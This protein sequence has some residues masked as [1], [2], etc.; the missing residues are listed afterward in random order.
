LAKIRS[1]TNLIFACLSPHPSFPPR[2][3]SLLWYPSRACRSC[4][5]RRLVRLFTHGTFLMAAPFLAPERATPWVAAA[6]SNYMVHKA[7][8]SG[9]FEV[10]YPASETVS[11]GDIKRGALV[12]LIPRSPTQ[13]ARPPLP[14]G[15][16]GKLHEPQFG[17]HIVARPIDNQPAVVIDPGSYSQRPFDQPLTSRPGG[18][19][20]GPT[21]IMFG[22]ALPINAWSLARCVHRLAL[23]DATTELTRLW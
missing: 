12:T 13:R 7:L 14:K 20:L 21:S 4:S 16:Q 18:T 5:S 2:T 23:R 17:L 19:G 3:A 8:S 11:Y 1:L 9:I 6:E 15:L 10:T 22:D